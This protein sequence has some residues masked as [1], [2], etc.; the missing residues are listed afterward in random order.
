MFCDRTIFEKK[1][2]TLLEIFQA[3]EQSFSTTTNLVNDKPKSFT[4]DGRRLHKMTNAQIL[5]ST[6]VVSVIHV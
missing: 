4:Q 6:V 5:N 2:T 3:L 1:P